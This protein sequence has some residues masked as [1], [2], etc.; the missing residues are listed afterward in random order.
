MNEPD[1]HKAKKNNTPA[2]DT[3]INSTSVLHSDKKQNT[4]TGDTPNNERSAP[5]DGPKKSYWK[6]LLEEKPDRH[7]ELGL[8][9]SIAFFA[10]AQLIMTCSSS[11]QTDKLISASQRNERAATKFAT[12]AQGINGGIGGAVIQ[13]GNQVGKLESGAHETQRLANATRDANKNASDA[14]RPWLA[15]IISIPVF[16]KNTRACHQMSQMVLAARWMAARK[17]RAVLS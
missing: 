12:A 16:E 8:S 13:L 11:D 15:L 6:R 7:I 2:D 10:L 3:V 1:S 14:E 5:Q 9:L 4:D 17:F